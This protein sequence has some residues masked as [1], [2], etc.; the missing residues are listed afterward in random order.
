MQHER[1][2]SAMRQLDDS[3]VEGVGEEAAALARCAA[4]V[5][6]GQDLCRGARKDQ[7]VGVA[8]DNGRAYARVGVGLVGNAMVVCTCG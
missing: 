8:I 4:S 6:D 5:D 1:L 2:F 7:A 3:A